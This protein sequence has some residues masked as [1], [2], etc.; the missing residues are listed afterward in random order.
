MLNF[1]ANTLAER[2]S[3][4]SFD[5]HS[6]HF[7]SQ[8]SCCVNTLV[9]VCTP[10]GMLTL[11]WGVSVRHRMPLEKLLQETWATKMSNTFSRTGETTYTVRECAEEHRI[12]IKLD[13]VLGDLNQQWISA[14]VHNVHTAC[15]VCASGT[16]EGHLIVIFLISNLL[17][18]HISSSSK[19]SF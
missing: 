6:C 19:W 2:V 10:V 18:D 7:H 15:I 4:L 3:V 1:N 16:A 17:I 12:V 5:W 14:A 13:P 8:L 11:Q 9:L